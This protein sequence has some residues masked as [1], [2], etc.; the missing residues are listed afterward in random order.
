MRGGN[1]RHD[2]WNE[3]RSILKIGGA[4]IPPDTMP[5]YV[6][7]ENLEIRSGRPPYGF[8]ADDGSAGSYILNAA[9]VFVEK[10]EHITIRNCRFHD[11]GNG[12][13]T[14]NQS[15]DVRI[16]GCHLYD[17]GNVGSAFEHNSYIEADGILF[18]YN[19]YGPL[20]A[21]CDG[22]NW[23]DRSTGCVIRYNWIESGNR[24]LDLVDTGQS[25]FYQDPAYRS[26]FVYGNILVEPD[27]AG[28]SQICHYGGDSGN[29]TRYRKGTLYF[30]NNTVVSTRSGNTTLL[31]LSSDDETAD[32]RNNIVFT[33][34]PGTP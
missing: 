2:F 31:R 10:G 9:A 23:K 7:V 20:R 25:A 14:A 27:G 21:G 34:A 19:H 5:R 3:D 26:T 32:L 13:F 33:T 18:Q 4:S 24:Q 17:N 6:V 29:L 15:S 30:Y 1:P 16:E 12:L 11:C 22:N 8:T 28:N